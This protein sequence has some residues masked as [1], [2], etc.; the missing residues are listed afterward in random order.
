MSNGNN[1]NKALRQPRILIAPLDW[2]LGHATRCIPII[3]ELLKRNC[4]VY[5]AAEGQTFSLLKNEFPDI[6]FLRLKGYGITYSRK[7][8]FL[9]FSLL[10]Q[11][12]K[13]LLS[14]VHERNWLKKTVSQFQLDAVISD[15]RFGM[16][17]KEVPC[18]YITHQLFIKTGN[19]VTEKIAQ[20]IHAYF[21][22]KYAQCWVPDFPE[23]GLAGKLSHPKKIPSNAIYLGPLSRFEELQN[24][25]KVYDLLI[26]ISG[27]EPQRTVFENIVFAQLEDF[28]GKVLVV[29]GLPGEK[30][31]MPETATLTIKNHLS[32][33]ELNIAFEEAGMVICRSGYT[34]I[35]DL[36]K[37]KKKAIL[38]AT[39]G[40]SEQE[41]LAQYLLE[42]K[43]FYSVEQNAF[44]LKEA[45]KA[46]SG[47]PFTASSQSLEEYK[48]VVNEFVRSIKTGN[49]APQ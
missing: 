12:P 11:L 43:Y 4:A 24:V 6:V 46:A 39:P 9:Q 18:I 7:P 22:R 13:I 36:I 23:Q 47:F 1:F 2:G 16:H 3:N 34:T 41:Y 21:I 8:T 10:M 31:R 17:C 38:V 25:A 49:F 35:M 5:I 37:L 14:I 26:S 27:P 45:L 29:R 28:T 20:K 33:K 42:K 44:S 40:Q 30:N 32:A 19:S 15:N 48:K